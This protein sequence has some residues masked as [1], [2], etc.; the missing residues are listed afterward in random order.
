MFFCK[1]MMLS[2]LCCVLHKL[3]RLLL[4]HIYMGRW[5]SHACIDHCIHVTEGL[6]WNSAITYPKHIY[7]LP[8]PSS[9]ETPH[10]QN[11]KFSKNL[12]HLTTFIS[13][14]NC[15][16]IS[17]ILTIKTI[18]LFYYLIYDCIF[19]SHVKTDW[20]LAQGNAQ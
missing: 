5:L 10:V 6:L 3:L 1:S 14:D 13:T 16:N 12:V 4:C 19:F 8:F 15:F 18:N 7:V 2:V 20:P 11:Y 17:S 9:S